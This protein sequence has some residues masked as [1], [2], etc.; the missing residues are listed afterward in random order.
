[1]FGLDI[2]WMMHSINTQTAADRFR[3]ELPEPEKVVLKNPQDQLDDMQEFAVRWTAAQP[4][5]TRNA[6]SIFRFLASS[7]FKAAK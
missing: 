2:C 1:V 4:Y 7:D 5:R 6:R 3:F